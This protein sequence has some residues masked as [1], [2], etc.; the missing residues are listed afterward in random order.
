MGNCKYYVGVDANISNENVG[1][2]ARCGFGVVVA[3]IA[4]RDDDFLERCVGM[5]VVAVLSKDTDIA[6]I[7][8]RYGESEIPVFPG[9]RSF[10]KWARKKRLCY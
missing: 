10:L 3:C 6:T 4:E 7:L 5:D 8:D 2:V 9:A 1:I